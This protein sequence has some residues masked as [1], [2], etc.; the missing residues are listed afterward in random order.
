MKDMT[1]S[2]MDAMLALEEEKRE[3]D[4]TLNSLKHFPKDKMIRKPERGDVS[5][6]VVDN[7][8]FKLKTPV[9]FS[10]AK[11]VVEAVECGFLRGDLRGSGFAFGYE[12]LGNNSEKTEILFYEG[13]KN[14]R[15]SHQP[16]YDYLD[17]EERVD[18]FEAYSDVYQPLLDKAVSWQDIKKEIEH[19][20]RISKKSNK[21]HL[22]Y[23][24]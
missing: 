13:G 23:K 1:I 7:N 5:I 21:Q 3:I 12:A 2:V 17:D 19:N 8:D 10:T 6:R 15:P 22:T 16:R 4:A 20:N 24:K 11:E 9:L 14:M 18:A